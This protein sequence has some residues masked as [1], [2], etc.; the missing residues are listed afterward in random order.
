MIYANLSMFVCC[1]FYVLKNYN[2]FQKIMQT[3]LKK[4]NNFYSW[5]FSELQHVLKFQEC[6]R[7]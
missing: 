4:L 3:R 6:L 2:R 1:V 5:F 7:G